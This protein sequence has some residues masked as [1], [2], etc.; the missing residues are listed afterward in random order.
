MILIPPIC[1][2]DLS[3]GPDLKPRREIDSGQGRPEA[4][5][6]CRGVAMPP[7]WESAMPIRTL[8]P[9]EW[10][11][12]FDRIGNALHGRRAEVKVT[13]PALGNRIVANGLPLIGISYDPKDDILALA[14]DG[15]HHISRRP[16][17]IYVRYA[18]EKLDGFEVIDG[19]KLSQTIQFRDPVKLPP[20]N[21]VARA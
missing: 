19:D 6:H 13:S 11:L 2:L 5:A 1:H 12:F 21:T 17:A 14:L 3:I 4:R 20:T 15:L 10:R 16:R 9:A 7:T 8:H 18:G